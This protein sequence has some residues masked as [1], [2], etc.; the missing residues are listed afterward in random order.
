MTTLEAHNATDE[1]VLV[2]LTLGATPGCVQD[3]STITFHPSVTL[4][5]V[6]PL[7]GSFTL[8]RHETVKIEAP[9]GLGLN[10]NLCFGTPPLNC[11]CPDWPEG[12]A[13]AEFIIDNGFQPGGQET[14]DISCVCGSNAYL[15]F[16][17]SAGDWTSNGGAIQVNQIRNDTRYKNT[18][19]VGVFPY[20]CD[21]CT[22]SVEPPTCVGQHPE[23]ANSIPICNVQ[24]P[25]DNNQGG[26]VKVSFF[27]WTPVPC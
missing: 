20:G 15:G 1:S 5:V 11:P 12:V 4:N 19:L 16:D 10:G 21:L 8:A 17:L 13:L 7:M 26:N 27:G 24:R 2:Y 3:V 14:V 23:F 22:A 9:D 18:G 25:A 6:A